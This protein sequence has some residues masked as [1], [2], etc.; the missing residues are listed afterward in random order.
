MPV[1][2]DFVACTTYT[3]VDLKFKASPHTKK[4][5][6]KKI[7]TIAKV[8]PSRIQTK[9]SNVLLLK[10]VNIKSPATSQVESSQII[11]FIF[12]LRWIP[13]NEGS[14]SKSCTSNT[15]HTPCLCDVQR[16]KYGVF[17]CPLKVF[18]CLPQCSCSSGNSSA[19]LII[20]VLGLR[21][22]QH[23]PQLCFTTFQY[24]TSFPVDIRLLRTS[25]HT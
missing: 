9:T 4:K 13:Q 8:P 20:L 10:L 15:S 24:P 11:S 1:F 16:L 3:S 2:N 12:L 5:Q 14:F 25:S 18:Q 23:L 21:A 7:S 22:I 19:L 6:S 17:H